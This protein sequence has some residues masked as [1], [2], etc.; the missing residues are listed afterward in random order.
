MLTLAKRP[1]PQLG[2]TAQS[3]IRMTEADYAKAMRKRAVMEGHLS[4]IVTIKPD[5]T[6]LDAISSGNTSTVEIAAYVG[7]SREHARKRLLK[8]ESIGM[9]SVVRKP[10][11]VWSLK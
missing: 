10:T 3:G 4:T 9:V 5:D 8:L 7:C 2:S 1:Q 11:T 6:F